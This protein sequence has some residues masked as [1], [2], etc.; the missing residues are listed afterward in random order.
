MTEEVWRDVKGYEGLYQVSN[1][2]RVKSLGRKDRFGRVIKERILEPAVTHNGYLRV[3][4][5]VDGK[6]KM[7]R[8]HRLVCEAFHEN[9]DNKSEVNHVNENKTDNRACNLEWSTR[10]E[11]CNHGS[12][13]ERVAKAL[14][15]PIG[16]FSLD[17]KLIKVWQ[18]ACEARRQTGFD[19]GYVGAVA[20]GKFK[21]AYGYI[22][23]Y[24]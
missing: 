12:R 6:R 11:N 21:Q 16:Q 13:N 19:Q 24:I 20:R 17:G 1:M 5:H 8:V 22:W 7:L 15:K 10:T 4:L 14:S 9:P 3:G 18:S 23:K 2:G